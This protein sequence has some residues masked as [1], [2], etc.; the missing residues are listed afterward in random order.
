MII[1]DEW[2]SYHK[3]IHSEIYTD[4]TVKII[5]DSW[6]RDP[7]KRIQNRLEKNKSTS[8]CIYEYKWKEWCWFLVN[9]SLIF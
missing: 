5:K 3:M 7:M 9:H 2:L 6:L 1:I 4:N 8:D